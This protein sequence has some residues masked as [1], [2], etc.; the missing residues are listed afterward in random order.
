MS[1][2]ELQVVVAG[3]RYALPVTAVIEATAFGDVT[4]IAGAPA[5]V[6]GVRPVRGQVLPVID[7]HV[8]FGL[9]LEAAPRWIVVVEHEQVVAGLAV[10]GL[11]DVAPA[12]PMR[13]S[14]SPLLAG[15]AT[16]DGALVGTIAID[17]LFERVAGV[18]A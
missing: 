13:P 5:A 9:P 6:M 18:A 11:L 8:V 1:P 15:E 2:T 3:E 4:R 17:A 12:G 7:L 14:E 16:A 10:D